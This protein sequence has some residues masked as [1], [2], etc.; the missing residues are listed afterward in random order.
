MSPKNGNIGEQADHNCKRNVKNM[1][2]IVA[3]V[4]A[5]MQEVASTMNAN[6]EDMEQFLDMNPSAAFSQSWEE[7]E[8]M[9]HKMQTLLKALEILK[10]GIQQEWMW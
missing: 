7:L 4:I 5:E 10:G 6:L 8:E 3:Q 9:T 1:K 2:K